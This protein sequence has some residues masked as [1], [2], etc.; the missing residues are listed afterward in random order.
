MRDFDELW[1]RAPN[2]LSQADQ[3]FASANHVSQPVF[4][5]YLNTMKAPLRNGKLCQTSKRAP[6]VVGRPGT[7]WMYLPD[8]AG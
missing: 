8:K 5:R 3:G 2:R 1:A 7:G 6:P 4:A